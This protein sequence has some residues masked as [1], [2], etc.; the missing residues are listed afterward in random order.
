[1]ES[2]LYLQKVINKIEKNIT[3]KISI[4]QLSSECYISPRQLYRDFYSLTGH[5]IN[6]YIR[7][8]RLSKALS[9]LKH[10]NMSITDIAYSCGYSSHQALCKAVKSTVFFTPNEYRNCD[11]TYYFP[12]CDEKQIRK[13][14]VENKTIPKMISIKYYYSQL[15]DIENRAIYYLQSV[16]PTYNGKLFGR[17]GHQQG[18][19]F[20]YELFIEYDEKHINKIDKSDF[21]ELTILSSYK[22]VFAQTAVNNIMQDINEAWDFLYGHWLKNS[23]FEIDNI[24]YFEEYIVKNNKIKQLVLHIP[25][26][27]R[28]NF[29]KINIQYFEERLFI[30]ASQKGINAE[31]SASNIVVDFVANLKLWECRFRFTTR[32]KGR[33]KMRL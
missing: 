14:S 7:K 4:E 33:I 32:Q 16:L 27:P 8:R 13:I 29:R 2:K 19:K 1:M 30:T 24:P 5:T 15:L 6:E 28:E 10:S 26:K 9:L 20:Y 25:V 18:N 22:A 17:N 23:M 21:K 3:K 11:D 31:K 12:L